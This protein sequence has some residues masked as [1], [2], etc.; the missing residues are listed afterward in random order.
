M[1]KK[2]FTVGDL[3]FAKV[4]GYPAWPARVTGR[5]IGG[6]Y[7]VF[8]YGTFE[9][10][11]MKPEDMWP[12]NQKLRDKFGPPN[13]HKKWYSEGLYQIEETPE[14]ALQQLGLNGGDVIKR[15][16]SSQV[17]TAASLT[18]VAASPVAVAL[19]LS[20]VS[21]V[22]DKSGSNMDRVGMTGLTVF[23]EASFFLAEARDWTEERVYSNASCILECARVVLKNSVSARHGEK[24]E[25]IKWLR[26]LAR[27]VPSFNIDTELLEPMLSSVNEFLDNIIVSLDEDCGA[28]VKSGLQ[29]MVTILLEHTGSVLEITRQQPGFGIAEV[30]SLMEYI[31]QI[32]QKT[33][34]HIDQVV[35]WRCK[36]KDIIFF[37]LEILESVHV[38]AVFQEELKIFNNI[39]DSLID[40]QF[41]LV[42]VDLKLTMLVC[43]ATTNLATKYA[44]IMSKVKYNTAMEKVCWRLCTQIVGM[45]E[46]LSE[47]ISFMEK[48][49]LDFKPSTNCQDL[50]DLKTLL[51]LFSEVS[52]QSSLLSF[53][54]QK[55]VISLLKNLLGI[56]VWDIEVY[57]SLQAEISIWWENLNE[58][59]RKNVLDTEC[60]GL[61][62]FESL[63]SF[64]SIEKG[65][66][67]DP[68]CE[69][70]E[71]LESLVSL[72]SIKK[73]ITEDPECEG[74][75]NFESYNEGERK[76]IRSVGSCSQV[77]GKEVGSEL[78]SSSGKSYF[79]LS[80]S[81]PL[82]PIS[83]SECQ[84]LP[85]VVVN[86][87]PPN[88]AGC[89]PIPGGSCSFFILSSLVPIDQTK[90][91]VPT[92]QSKKKKKP[93]PKRHSGSSKLF[94]NKVKKSKLITQ[95][96]Q[97]QRQTNLSKFKSMKQVNGVFKCS[98]C[99]FESGW[100][101]KAW[102][103][104][105]RCGLNM[106][107]GPR[108]PKVK[109]CG[110]CQE[111]FRSQKDL[112]KHFRSK[113]Q[114][115]SYYCVLCPKP[116]SFKFK[117]SFK[118]HC[119]LKHNNSKAAT[120]FNC[121]W[122]RYQ[123]TQKSNL[124]RHIL[125]LHKNV[126]FADSLVDFVIEE[127]INEIGLC[128]YERIRLNN[129]REKR[130]VFQEL[131]PDREISSQ[132]PVQSQ[133]VRRRPVPQKSR[134]SSRLAV[135]LKDVCV[136]PR[137]DPV[138]SVVDEVDLQDGLGKENCCLICEFKCSRK[139]NL[140]RHVIK[141]HKPLEEPLHC[142]RSFCNLSFATRWQK[143]V[144]V[145]ECWLICQEEQC[146]GKQF[147]RQDKYSQHIRMHKRRDD[148]IEN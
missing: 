124:R 136:A 1:V 92:K 57:R 123:A 145:A 143:E 113:H 3:V 6:K 24:F 49:K 38:R 144:H 142:S 99:S 51:I 134:I 133:K 59:N 28:D 8:F 46:K 120:M 114:V 68:E 50:Q 117:N 47:K 91:K 112:I 121:I 58:N 14:I 89:V 70:L 109:T 21:V 40:L 90:A 129:L 119:Q 139:Y 103:H 80:L 110:T 29:D 147:R 100:K 132:S 148:L 125:R 27:F 146:K 79:Q 31:P 36:V 25:C 105:S 126:A 39:A 106:K 131:F 138:S 19:P 101:S 83:R 141:Q 22:P 37:F 73:C 10:G 107:K 33:L 64:G 72:G 9:V 97:K 93:Q 44:R 17:A 2:V 140:S 43:S 111:I 84:H 74:L 62:N 26:L 104:S 95:N 18:E 127:A 53:E 115:S 69:G 45:V 82:L 4:K 30:P 5:T 85:E 55:Q 11:K 76:R 78:T 66:T 122:C 41:I 71:N 81:F 52:S 102:S 130:K 61:A 48:L 75:E 60:E 35:G 86:K 77:V 13:M 94:E 32:L 67:E 7:C 116:T 34:T 54:D 65:V 88:L 137:S 118:R 128:E 15:D 23:K 16:P 87:S 56:S 108:K 42:N 63:E 12:Y 20:E 98:I 96:L 135:P